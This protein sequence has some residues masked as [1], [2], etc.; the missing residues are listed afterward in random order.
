MIY[1]IYAFSPSSFLNT[2]MPNAIGIRRVLYDALQVWSRSSV[3][4]FREVHGDD[5]DIRVMFA[6]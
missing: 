4:K 2:S 1:C 6:R 5:A 3:L